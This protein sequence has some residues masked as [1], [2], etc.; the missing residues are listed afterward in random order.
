MLRRQTAEEEKKD[1]DP[2]GAKTDDDD[3]DGTASF[4]QKGANSSRSSKRFD[5]DPVKGRSTNHARSSKIGLLAVLVVCIVLVAINRSAASSYSY[6]GPSATTA[7]STKLL[8]SRSIPKDR[9]GIIRF[10]CPANYEENTITGD[11]GESFEENYSSVSRDITS[12]K[13]EFLSTFRKMK[14]DAW[15]QTYNQIKKGTTPFKSKYFPKYLNPGMHVYESACGIGLN[16][17]MTLEILE[18]FGIDGITVYGNEYVRESAEKATSVVLSEGVIPAGNRRGVVCPGDS[19]NLAH[20]PSG[21]FD[22][23]YTGYLTPFQDPLL[24]HTGEPEWDDY[25]EYDAVCRS[26]W[27]SKR[28]GKT[29]ARNNDWMGKY[30]WERVIVPAQ[31]DWYGKWVGEMARIAKPGVP[32]IVEQASLPYC[33]DNDDWGGVAKSFW[34]EAAKENTYNWNVDPD[35][36]EIM[37]DKIHERR[38]NVFMLKKK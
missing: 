3:D 8:G 5:S 32:V 33:A 20:V 21:A 18:E 28:K 11:S 17:F 37:G 16:L 30:L 9:N 1:G 10:S 22:L 14:F 26:F 6:S 36:I 31:R 24:L 35:S 25:T 34:K 38:Y 19:S 13:T 12:N 15:G 29:E 7:A 4:L 2:S 23:V 27:R